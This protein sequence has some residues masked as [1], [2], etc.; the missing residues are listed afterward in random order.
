LRF[1]P[2]D[3]LA[4]FLSGA[5]LTIDEQYGGWNGEPRVDTSLEIITVARRDA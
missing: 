2:V 3:S 5:G 4:S 1:L